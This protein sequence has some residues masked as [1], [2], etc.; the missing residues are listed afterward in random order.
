M[1]KTNR[2]VGIAAYDNVGK[3]IPAKQGLVASKV[4]RKNKRR[5]SYKKDLR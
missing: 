2:G 3:G 1:G 4:W 5:S